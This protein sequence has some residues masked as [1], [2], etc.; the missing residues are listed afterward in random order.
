MATQQ[1]TSAPP[2]DTVDAIVLPDETTHYP[3]N[4]PAGP[5]L[6]SVVQSH[7]VHEVD[8]SFLD[9]ASLLM[10][11]PMSGSHFPAPTNVISASLTTASPAFIPDVATA[12]TLTLPTPLNS[13][14]VS[15]AAA[16]RGPAISGVGQSPF[17]SVFPPAYD[18]GGAPS[19]D[20][21]LDPSIAATIP[22]RTPP[23]AGSVLA[24]SFATP[25]TSVLSF[26]TLEPVLPKKEEIS[27]V[28]VA[29]SVDAVKE[30]LADIEETAKHTRAMF[31]TT[32]DVF[33][34]SG[35]DHL[36]ERIGQVTQKFAGLASISTLGSSTAYNSPLNSPEIISH[37]PKESPLAFASSAMSTA[38][39]SVDPSALDH[40]RKR[41]GQELE[42]RRNVK[43]P[44]REPTDDVP[45]LSFNS[46]SNPGEMGSNFDAGDLTFPVQPV[47]FP[48]PGLHPTQLSSHG[49][50][51]A[52]QPTHFSSFPAIPHDGM[53]YTPLSMP[54]AVPPLSTP[55]LWSDAKVSTNR[56]SFTNSAANSSHLSTNQILP[57]V[58]EQFTSTSGP[59]QV[60]ISLDSTSM[61]MDPSVEKPGSVHSASP[62]LRSFAFGHARP[63]SQLN[64]IINPPPLNVDSAWTPDVDV[65][66]SIS[67]SPKKYTLN[68]APIKNEGSVRVDDENEDYGPDSDDEDP[69][70]MK[71][72]QFSSDAPSS[73]SVVS[74]IPVE[75]RN[76]VDRI[77]FEFL[78]GICSNLDATD[79]KGEPIHQT[80]MAKKMQRL[81]ESPDFRPFKFRIQ[82]FTHA[83]L[84][85]L[86]RRG[87]AED[88]IPMKKVRNYLWR[89]PYILRF[90]E[91][92]KKAKSKGNH[93][94]NVEAKKVGDGK[95]QFRPFHRK[96]AGTPPSVAYCGLLWSWSP[97]VWD[98]QASWQNIPVK[99]SSPNLPSWLSWN[100]DVLSGVPPP[101]AQSCRI[102]VIAKF[103]L[104]GQ[105]GTLSH[106]FFLTVAP[107]S[108]SES[109]SLGRSYRPSLAGEL[110]HL[111]N[112]DTAPVQSIHRERTCGIPTARPSQADNR[113]MRVIQS[114]AQRVTEETESRFVSAL[115]AKASDLQDLVKTKHVL[116]QTVDAFD[117]AIYGE[118]ESGSRR[119]AV[120]AQHVV[121]QA[122]H[123]VIA[124]RT[125]TDAVVP[126][127]QPEAVTLG[128]LSDATQN[129]IA[130]AV[131]IEGTTSTEVDIMVSA[132]SILKSR[133]VGPSDHS[134]SGPEKVVLQNT[135]YALISL[136]SDYV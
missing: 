76:E 64:A 26:S 48:P 20:S 38:T 36:S 104:D 15:L 71:C 59:F 130:Q 51:D 58:A 7:I 4:H 43:A 119:L 1:D 69:V 54:N 19:L 75:Y 57:E 46:A 32:H 82:A 90:N 63:R 106:G 98:P 101:D 129:A 113:V 24:Q 103:T 35:I 78:N 117:K 70:N 134:P 72:A 84:E 3:K 55:P 83:F 31:D 67:S 29:E 133:T 56:H 14:S 21:T 80:L 91:D 13:G 88:R 124:D 125:T 39:A 73:S 136:V 94:W 8:G 22:I 127:P 131:K 77:F 111:G 105:E 44:K 109:P 128:E 89:S 10:Q 40:S 86:A 37:E 52:I 50:I 5:N 23:M 81:D 27:P 25:P 12:E 115:S 99:Y 96:L 68:T 122:A 28:A 74:E 126:V 79:S 112:N 16:S 53:E 107:V 17:S 120:A 87:Y 30:I 47:S 11:V 93:I 18:F 60:P 132:T 61:T 41:Y 108:S 66:P 65:P 121:I 97:H 116:D 100:G 33:T 9:P 102:T 114:V 6:S 45:L 2:L 95:W 92:G 118:N 34:S 123:T 49:Q 62:T 135:S 110:S 42:E 85:E